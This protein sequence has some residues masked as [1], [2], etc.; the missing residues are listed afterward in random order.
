MATTSPEMSP[1]RSEPLALPLRFNRPPP[2]A[3][4]GR[5]TS[6]W[7]AME[8]WMS[9]GPTMATRCRAGASLMPAALCRCGGHMSGTKCSSWFCR[10]VLSRTLAASCRRG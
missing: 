1:E 6:V 3:P 2:L 4:C 7:W 9:W 8:R 5:P 10:A